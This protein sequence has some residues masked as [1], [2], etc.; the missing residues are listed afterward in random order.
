[1]ARQDGSGALQTIFSFF[2]GLMVTAF[3]GVGVYTF[4][5]PDDS[6]EGQL[7]ELDREEQ[8]AG[9][10]RTT[11]EL[12][13]EDRA[14]MQAR[15]DARSAVMEAQREARDA[16]G[17]STSIILIA[18]ATLVMAISL[19]RAEQLPVLSNGLLLG[20]VL[21][22]VYGV[23]WIVASDTTLTRFLV[24]TVA[25]AITLGLGYLR[26]VRPGAAGGAMAMQGAVHPDAAAI[27]ARLRLLETRMEDAAAAFGARKD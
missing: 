10:D 22:M 2:L 1:M 19:V 18:L 15:M 4:H 24:L 11:T 25:L 21:T 23:G 9:I 7:R 14:A 3:V 5:P 16:W 27:E 6:F 12:T 8:V 13:A 26:F 20:G 17:R